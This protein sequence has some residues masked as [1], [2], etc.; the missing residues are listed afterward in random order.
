MRMVGGEQHYHNSHPC[1]IIGHIKNIYLHSC[2]I[3]WRA[4]F[5]MRRKTKMC[6]AWK[7]SRKSLKYLCLIHL[8]ICFIHKDGK[9]IVSFL[10]LLTASEASLLL[11][12]IVWHTENRMR[13]L[14]A[15]KEDISILN[16]CQTPWLVPTE[17]FGVEKYENRNGTLYKILKL[18]ETAT[19]WAPTF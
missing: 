4:I 8:L 13:V 19:D 17:L 12:H 3:E 16:I 5:I 11:A 18:Y 14:V 1:L 15:V 9:G 2:A 6:K 7:D 10:P